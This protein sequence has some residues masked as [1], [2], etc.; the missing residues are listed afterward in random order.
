MQDCK[1]TH[2]QARCLLCSCVYTHIQDILPPEEDR[3]LFASLARGG[4]GRHGNPRG[5][6]VGAGSPWSPPHR[7]KPRSWLCTRHPRVWTCSRTR[8]C[9]C[10]PSLSQLLLTLSPRSCW[11]PRPSG[12]EA[13]WSIPRAP[14]W[15]HRLPPPRRVMV[16]GSAHAH[17]DTADKNCTGA[18]CFTKQQTLLPLALRL[19]LFLINWII[20]FLLQ[21]FYHLRL[22]CGWREA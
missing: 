19:L 20:C 10:S 8:N 12:W 9:H 5:H 17:G 4:Q 21:L 18:S 6:T 11:A 7:A 3:E 1:W 13:P 14:S 2:L 15:G 16:C 22:Q